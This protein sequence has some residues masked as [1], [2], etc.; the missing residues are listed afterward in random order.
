MTTL[1]YQVL[2][3]EE[4]LALALNGWMDNALKE[5]TAHAVS[6]LFDDV[7]H[8]ALL[9]YLRSFGILHLQFCMQGL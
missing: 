3:E 8:F 5:G 2:I 9:S 6:F 7:P 1:P 4:Q